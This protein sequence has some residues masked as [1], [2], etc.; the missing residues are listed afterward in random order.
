MKEYSKPKLVCIQFQMLDVL[1][2]NSVPDDQQY[3]PE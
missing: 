2:N 3:D 1:T